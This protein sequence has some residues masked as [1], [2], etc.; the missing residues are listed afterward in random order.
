MSYVLTIDFESHDPYIDELGPGWAYGMLEVV[1]MSYKFNDEKETHCTD[2]V[3][4]I[5]ELILG[6][7]TIITHNAQY[8][9]GICEMLLPGLA[10][11]K[12]LILIDTIML[13]FLHDNRDRSFSLDYLSRK[14]LPH[15]GLKSNDEMIDIVFKHKLTRAKDPKAPKNRLEA[16]TF[17]K[18]N[19]KLLYELE[20]GTVIA[21]CKQ[22]TVLCHGLYKKFLSK[23][24]NVVF[25]SDLIKALIKMRM[26]GIAINVEGMYNLHCKWQKRL[27]QILDQLK[28]LSG[29]TDFDPNKK[30][31][32]V[33][34]FLKHKIALPTTG[35]TDRF[36]E[37]QPSVTGDWLAEQDNELCNL[38]AEYKI[39]NKIDND[40]VS[41]SLRM[42]SMLPEQF[43]GKIYP[44]FT[45]FGTDT[46]RFSSSKP[47]MQNI[48]NQKKRK[49]M[50]TALRSLYLASPGKYWASID[51]GQQEPRLQT[52]Y[53][54]LIGAEGADLLVQEYKNNPNLN[55][56]ELVAKLT[57]ISKD[58]AKILNF[59]LSYGSGITSIAESLGISYAEAE[60]F[61]SDFHA[62]TPFLKTLMDST[63][64]A[65]KRNK[66]IR[67]IGG[68][69]T[70]LP[71]AAYNKK[72]DKMFSNERNGLNYLLQGGGAD[73]ITMAVVELDKQGFTMLSSIHDEINLEVSSVA[74]GLRAKK[75]MEEVL[76]LRVPVVAELK[77]G[78]TW[79]NGKVVT[80]DDNKVEIKING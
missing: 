66:H 72:Y 71:P 57:G 50:G 38:L 7:H 10:L 19:M 24:S 37:G 43:K 48:P 25:Y 64:D 55:L 80:E 2:D 27:V 47:N 14:Y 58:Q 63:K 22:D 23:D 53:A 56:H 78:T 30:T 34:L 77:I 62:K 1:C 54:S 40:F 17:S 32:L 15:L 75:I 16:L 73:Q 11:N 9:I 26:R 35:P 41:K 68:R 46:G 20:P 61:I 21:Y 39:I 29:N 18:K 33:Q 59:K 13:G 76:Q 69:Y 79:G 31:D 60:V 52:H 74:E 3:E 12:D 65:F 42:Q 44:T 67:T 8:D 4:K 51:Y 49:E 5:K 70:R 36:P 45:P 28:A 6:A